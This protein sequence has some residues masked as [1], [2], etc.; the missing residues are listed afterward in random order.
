MR[1]KEPSRNR[2]DVPPRLAGHRLAALVHGNRLA[3]L[4]HGN[5]FLGSLKFKSSGPARSVSTDTVEAL[6][7]SGQ[8]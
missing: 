2:V 5:R 4:V 3:A 6:Y 1:A 7:L 8:R